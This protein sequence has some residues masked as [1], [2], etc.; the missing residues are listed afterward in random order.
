VVTG[1]LVLVSLAL[2]LL[3]QAVVGSG[4]GIVAATLILLGLGMG[5]AMAPA[6][7]S[8]M[9]ALPR[10]KASVGSAMNDTTRMVG[11]ALGVAVLGSILSS[12]YR[13]DI[14]AAAAH[15]P[16]PAA[17]VA[18]DSLGGALQVAGT[19]GA[20]VD[21]ARHAFVS[22]MHTAALVAAGVAL[23]GAVLAAVFLPA[24][25]ARHEDETS[26]APVAEPLPA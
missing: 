8:V 15:L 10:A 24:R 17:D 13:H 6:T 23:A 7:D 14:D 2:A 19:D 5:S 11:S 1:G 21:A 4:Y 3:T 9:G 26:V 22:G 12:G 18:R 16:G 20:L 25:E